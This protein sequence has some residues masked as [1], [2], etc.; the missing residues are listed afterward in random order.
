MFLQWKL[1][2]KNEIKYGYGGYLLPAAV[3]L[4]K[5]QLQ[6]LNVSRNRVLLDQQN[7]SFL[8][9]TFIC[10]EN[11]K[12]C[13]IGLSISNKLSYNHKAKSLFLLNK[14]QTSFCNG[15]SIIIC[16][17]SMFSHHQLLLLTLP[18]LFVSSNR[19]SLDYS[20]TCGGKMQ[21]FVCLFKK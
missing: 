12:P 6:I 15:T 11:L 17:L 1:N 5:K 4:K 21:M 13:I 2:E 18:I 3:L 8:W 9:D 20:A 19:S 16:I 14:V 10:L 7:F